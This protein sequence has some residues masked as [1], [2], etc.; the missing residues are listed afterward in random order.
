MYVIIHS[1]FCDKNNKVK[2][3][4]IRILLLIIIF[5]CF[6]TIFT[7]SFILPRII[8][9]NN[10]YI[11]LNNTPEQENIKIAFISDTH[12][13][14]YKKTNF[15]QNVA[16]KIE[17]LEP[18]V[19]ILGG[20]LIF[21]RGE[22]AIY[23]EPLAKL[24]NKFPV[25]AVFGNHES[26]QGFLNDPRRKDK[27]QQLRTLFANWNIKILENENEIIK[28]NDQEIAILGT[29]E[30]WTDEVDFEPTLKSLSSE[31]PKILISHNPDIIYNEKTSNIDLILSGHTHA[32]QIALPFIGPIPPVGTELGRD[33]SSGLFKIEDTLL[34]ISSGIGE[35]GP[36]ARLFTLPE[37]ALINIDL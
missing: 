37:I 32:G 2:T 4:L 5:I 1:F 6:A 30:L 28:I 24:T 14:R 10:V 7:G 26:N 13:G 3:K 25:Y 11:N 18:D 20:D 33:I 9:T 8:A 12:V 21:K 34:Y 29:K 15:I 27:S 17:Q 31:I 19:L 35:S 36:R 23:L 22:Y 16:D